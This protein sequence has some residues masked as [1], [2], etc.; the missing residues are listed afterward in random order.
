[1]S[2]SAKKLL[3]QGLLTLPVVVML[4]GCGMDDKSVSS[5]S[6]GDTV[7][8][9]EAKVRVAGSAVKG[10]IQQGLVTANRLV[11][12][13]AGYFQVDRLAAKPVRTDND[14]HYEL[15]M[16][17]K[18][19]GWAIVQLQADSSTRM[20]CDVL[21]HCEQ[22][23]AEPVPFGGSFVLD[24]NFT[25]R[26][27]GDLAN[28]VIYLTPLTQLAVGIAERSANGLSAEALNTAYQDVETWFGLSAGALRLAPPD[29]TKLDQTL[30]A[31]ADAIQLA[32]LNAAFLALVNDDP[33]WGSITDVLN[34]MM[35]QVALNGR[36]D[37]LGTGD[38]LS[39]SDIVDASAM[40]AS[41][42]QLTVQSSTMSQKL[43]IVAHR[44][45]QRFKTL[46][47]VY[48]GENGGIA[49]SDGTGSESP[50]DGT[51]GDGGGETT[52]GGTDPVTPVDSVDPVAQEPIPEPV[53]PVDL[54]PA[55]AALLTWQA[56]F[57]R[58]N[59]DSLSMGEIAGYEIGYGTSADLLNQTLAIGEASTDTMLI[60]DLA[61]GSWYFAI[62]TIDVDGNRSRWS[63]VVSKTIGI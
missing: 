16:R 61:Q 29:L 11:A 55:N 45:Y 47:D 7:T 28:G 53:D 51:T 24:S 27:A 42:L 40:Q 13:S 6:A 5:Q 57:T 63:D 52:V 4:S 35:S 3:K 48:S 18:A 54:V 60:N 41:E 43:A 26:G 30:D 25:L 36:L 33:K 37:I 58:E 10:V 46:A 23:G 12:D 1:M 44:N 31:S 15:R 59:G 56:P 20:T 34:D 19:E 50:T 22:V 14:G 38:N 21:P 17:G 49:D 62:R 2:Y 8:V 39:L 32:V 9:G